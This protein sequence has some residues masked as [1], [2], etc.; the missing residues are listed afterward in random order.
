MAGELEGFIWEIVSIRL[1]REMGS[2]EFN[3]AGFGEENDKT[4]AGKERERDI[5]E[6]QYS[7]RCF[8]SNKKHLLHT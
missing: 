3:M 8:A 2:K 5:A 6:L 4:W 7:M 1:C